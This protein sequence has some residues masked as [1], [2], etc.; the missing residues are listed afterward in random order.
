MPAVPV[1]ARSCLAAAGRSLCGVRRSHKHAEQNA[2]QLLSTYLPATATRSS[3]E[4]LQA[5]AGKAFVDGAPRIETRLRKQLLPEERNDARGTLVV[6]GLRA[7]VRYDPS[8]DRGTS[9]L[10]LEVCFGRFAYLR[11]RQALIDWERM[12][13]GDRRPGRAKHPREL[14]PLSDELDAATSTALEDVYADHDQ[15]EA[16]VARSTF[17]GK[18]LNVWITDTLDR[19]AAG[20]SRS[21]T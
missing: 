5:L 20:F 6:A 11:M 15:V 9:T 17:E 4:R 16:W 3:G 18:P 19:A 8:L 14:V 7:A 1:P 10:S 13:F 2:A 21:A 12:T